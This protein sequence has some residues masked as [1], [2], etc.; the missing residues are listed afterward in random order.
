MFHTGG[1]F[2]HALPVLAS[3][4][5]V[6]ILRRWDAAKLL[7]LVP[8]EKL[9]VFFAVPTQLQEMASREGFSNAD[10]S[11][12]RLLISGGAPLPLH[13][14]RVYREAHRVP[15]A[16]GFG[17]TEFGP[18]A[19]MLPP[20]EAEA[21]VGSIGKPNYFVD[22]AVLDDGGGVAPPGQVGELCLRG[23][24]LCSGYFG[25]DGTALGDDG[26]FHTGDLARVDDGYFT[27]VGRSKDMFVSGG[28][29]VYPLEIEDALYLHASVKQC[30]VVGVP[31]ERWGEVGHAFVTLKD[32]ADVR[33]AD[34]V[35]FL[36]TR[37]AG[38]KVPRRI[39]LVA[40]LPTSAAGKILKTTLRER[41]CARRGAA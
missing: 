36:R 2:V 3:G 33:E 38:Y 40:E 22:A 30:A 28:E 21:R 10:L 35:A 31:D 26:W 24:A 11:S 1:L 18:N 32:G 16:Q 27:I 9:S 23:G 4:G 37:L 39:D 15:V 29:N 7:D 8:R 12:I 13:V 19:L 17:M 6:V 34:L 41:A 25:K 20:E 14:P 5:R